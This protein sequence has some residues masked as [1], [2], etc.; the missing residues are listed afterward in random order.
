MRDN[1]KVKFAELM[2][3]TAEMYGKTASKVLMNMYFNALQRYSIDQ[4]SEGFNK[5][6]LDEKHG[7]F[8]PKPADIIRH[9]QEPKQLQ[10]ESKG[11]LSWC[12]GTQTL[13]NVYGPDTKWFM[14][15]QNAD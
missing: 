7:S 9:M 1:D 15:T 11:S 4:V 3:G 6:I 10:I 8:M 2:A 14:E 12:E 13:L 5:H